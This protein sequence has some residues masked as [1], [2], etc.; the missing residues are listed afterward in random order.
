MIQELD[1]SALLHL[2]TTARHDY[3]RLDS[4]FVRGKLSESLIRC[5][6]KHA[7]SMRFDDP[8]MGVNYAF[9]VSGVEVDL[10]YAPAENRR[11]LLNVRFPVE[12]FAR[13]G[14]EHEVE[15]TNLRILRKKV[16][17]G[18]SGTVDLPRAVAFP[19]YLPLRIDP[20]AWQM[21]KSKLADWRYEQTVDGYEV[22]LYTYFDGLRRESS[23][24]FR[25]SAQFIADRLV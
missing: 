8:D 19:R 3:R 13:R 11:S 17:T 12:P 2:F 1:D 7:D 25:R 22:P 6:P 23:P 14:Q 18:S 9:D 10:G 21:A 20:V 4:H 5:S 24:A 16:A 15:W